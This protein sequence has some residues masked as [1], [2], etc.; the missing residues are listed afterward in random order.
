MKFATIRTGAR[1]ADGDILLQAVLHNFRRI[2]AA[3]RGFRG[4][5]A[6]ASVIYVSYVKG[7]SAI[8]LHRSNCGMLHLCCSKRA[9]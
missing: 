2:H 5:M 3:K 9:A 8:P 1:A 6:A 4:R 7:L